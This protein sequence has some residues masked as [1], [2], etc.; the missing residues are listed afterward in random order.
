MAHP[1]QIEWCSKVK[2][3]LPQHFTGKRVLDCGALDI[4]G[5]NRYLFTD[6]EY[7]GIDVVAGPNV[8]IV[9]ETAKH[10]VPDGHY[11]TIVSTECFEHDFHWMASLKAIRRM[12]ASGGLFLFSCA[13]TGRAEHGTA[14]CKPQDAPGLP[15]SEY[16]R[17]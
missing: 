17:N 4:N 13:T 7:T 2:A 16:Y 11:E 6:C 9:V 8:D 3:L 15:W 1:Q 5:N 12:L 10:T 14:R